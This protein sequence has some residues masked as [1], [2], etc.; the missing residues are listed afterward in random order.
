MT[1]LRTGRPARKTT[2]TEVHVDD[3]RAQDLDELRRSEARLRALVEAS[4]VAVWSADAFG[5]ATSM[6]AVGSSPHFDVEEITGDRWL[7]AVHPDDRAASA[8]A[9]TRALF[10]GERVVILERKR[11]RSGDWRWVEVRAA[12]IG[13]VP[14][15]IDE[16]VGTI[17][18]VHDSR[19]ALDGVRISEE[20]L[21]LAL[22]VGGL[23]TWDVDLTA[24]ARDWSEETRRILGFPPDTPARIEAVLATIHPE[25]R[26]RVAASLENDGILAFPDTRTEF[27]IRRADDGTV[28]WLETSARTVYDAEGRP[29]RRIGIVQDVTARREQ[30][31]AVRAAEQRLRLALKAGRMFAWERDL[32]TDEVT[33]CENARELIGLGSGPFSE[34]LARVHPDDRERAARTTRR[35]VQNTSDGQLRFVR[36]DGQE[37]WLAARSMEIEEEGRRKLVGVTF[38]MTDR[39]RAEEQLWAAANHDALTGL[40]NRVFLHRSLGELIDEAGHAGGDLAVLAIGIDGFREVNDVMGQDVG[41]ALLAEFARRLRDLCATSGFAGRLGGDEF[42]IVQPR[43][44]VEQVAARAAE[45]LRVL[46]R[47]FVVEGRTVEP[48]ACIGIALGPIHGERAEALLTNARI[49]LARAKTLGRRRVVV[50]ASEHRDAVEERLRIAVSVRRGLDR[51]AFVPFYQPKTCLRTGEIVGFEALVRRREEDGTVVGPAAFAAALSDPD[52]APRI[53]RTMLEAVGRDMR[54]WLDRGL[55]VGRVAVNLSAAEFSD[56]GLAERILETASRARLPLDRLEIEVTETVLLDRADDTAALTLERLHRAGIAIALD[57]FGTGFASL[58]HLRLYPV[59]HIKIDRSFVA[60]MAESPGDAA[61]VRS[62][63][64]LGRHLGLKVTAEGVETRAQADALRAAGC[65]YAQGFLYAPAV[66]SEAVPT[67]LAKAP[68]TAS[69]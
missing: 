15:R 9:W 14:G 43:C 8:A 37:L 56:R 60:R 3:T 6:R 40:P 10:A 64:D 50:F 53:G 20:R 66:A 57:D 22:E 1:A 45:A 69:R 54:D 23:G 13:S 35:P 25:D 18:D 12:P 61:I 34:F 44:G 5:R 19:T 2:T 26:A 55:S 16:W 4:A 41:D 46:S 68:R 31:R 42:A 38:D 59:D 51:N 47:D 27:R 65:D 32:E 28:R 63:V 36:A 67:L 52:L 17:V 11:T 29:I 58:S 24:G 21:R 30:E 33:R 49:A 62:V 48:S 7:D 39:K